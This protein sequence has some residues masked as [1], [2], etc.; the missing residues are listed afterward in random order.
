M[1]GPGF[2]ARGA[3]APGFPGNVLIGRGP[4]FAWSL[5]SAGNDL[6]DHY[7]ETLCGG[8]RLATATRASA[9]R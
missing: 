3:T 8:S 7:V 6:I 2:E 9:A 5:T 4:D 1:Q